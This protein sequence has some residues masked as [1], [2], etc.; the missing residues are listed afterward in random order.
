MAGVALV[1]LGSISTL[2]MFYSFYMLNALGYVCGGPLPNQVLLSRWFNKSR[3]RAMGFAYLG[4]GLG[5]AAVPWI[6]H[7]LVGRFGWQAALKILGLLIVVIAFP[8]AF[9]VKEHPQPERLPAGNSSSVT[10]GCFRTV[11]FL[12]LIAG[13]MCSIAA[14]SGTQQNLK[15]FLS[16]DQHYSQGAAARVL[17]LI[18]MF[19]LVGRLLMGW[20][21]DHFPKKYVMLLIYTLVAAAIP[22]LL[23]AQ[24]PQT[25]Y[26]F[27]IVFGIALGGDYMIIPLMTA[28]IFG[29]QVLGTLLG[30]ILTADGVA[31]AVSPW[32]M[33]R[34]R[35]VSGTYSH[36]FLVLIAMAL[37]GAAATAALPQRG[38]PE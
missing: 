23:L 27:A 22:L 30:V 9:L 10:R 38:W 26:V 33:G 20:L 5:G 6:S 36:G 18:L 3:G 11:P 25:I 4:I 29:T 1:G 19:S 13:S 2:G 14:V 17:S 15:L 8:M 31:E 16:L 34:A 7:A 12:L 28:E 37:L 21:A 24:S 32:M 35:D